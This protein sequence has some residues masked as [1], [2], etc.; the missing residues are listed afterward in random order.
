MVFPR[1][2]DYDRKDRSIQMQQID[3]VQIRFGLEY[4]LH[5]PYIL[6]LA[7]ETITNFDIKA[8]QVVDHDSGAVISTA[9]IQESPILGQQ[10]CLSVK[11]QSIK[12]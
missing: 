12:V 10:T 4:I 8:K 1:G 9:F 6:H 7:V 2:F 5:R 3:A 11:V